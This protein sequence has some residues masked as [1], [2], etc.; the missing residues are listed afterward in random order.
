[1][2]D[3]LVLTVAGLSKHFVLHNVDGR[4][5]D[6][7]HTVDL[8]VRAGEHVA[9][10]GSSGAG[11]SSLLKCINRTYLASAGVIILHAEDG[12]S[13]PLDA[14]SDREMASLRGRDIG[15]VSQFLRSQPRRTPMEIVVRSAVLRGVDRRHATEA[16]AD[17]LTRLR[18]DR[19]LWDV[20]ASVLSGGERQRVN[21]A[22]GTVAP[23][24]LLLLD[25]PVSALDPANRSAALDLI[26]GL[27]SHGVAVLSVFHDLEAMERLA[28]RVVVMSD[29]RV[30]GEGAPSEVLPE[31][32]VAR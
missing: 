31:L 13:T 25:E 3:R 8:T 20:H 28:T 21:L 26:A 4:R 17:A 9:L 23:P 6:A 32:E 11:K 5:V 15:Y 14:L 18:L 27:T 10:A 30:V 1:M 22:A 29:G 24:K 16:A 12:S 19:A 7:L 2:T